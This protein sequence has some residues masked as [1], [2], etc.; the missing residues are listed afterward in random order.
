MEEKMLKK[1]IYKIAK[2]YE[3]LEAS[4]VNQ[5][6]LETPNHQYTT[7]SYRENV[8]MSLFERMIPKKYCIEQGVFI[9]DSFGNISSE[10]DLAV[11]DET[12]TPYIFNYGK[13]KFIPIEAVSV[14][15]QCKSK[16]KGK[17]MQV[18]LNEWTDSIDRLKTS[19]DSVS[20]IITDLVDN[21]DETLVNDKRN[22]NMTQTST[23]PV[24]ILCATG[25]TGPMK[26]KLKEKF[27]ILLYI[28][29]EH[30]VKKINGE[31]NDFLEWNDSLNHYNYDRYSPEER[32]YR[33][34][35]RNDGDCM[36]SKKAIGERKLSDL[37]VKDSSGQENIIMSLTFQLNQ[38]LMLINNPM[39]FPHRAYAQCFTRILEGQIRE[40]E[41]E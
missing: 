36:R 34:M 1:T 25:I 14:V 35:R 12:Y 22:K 37:N 40:E 18:N 27:D 10:V 33:K 30:L 32:E 2:N 8:W 5:L 6:S 3:S 15:I 31:T 38:L 26:E 28:K 9:I 13:I 17:A 41:R 11:Y 16:V 7:G 39:L 20:R 23:R 24:K 21:H 4:L 19:L 29:K